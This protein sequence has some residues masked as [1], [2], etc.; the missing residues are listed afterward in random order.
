MEA[1]YYSVLFILAGLL[2]RLSLIDIQ[3][4]RLPNPLVLAV[5]ILGLLLVFAT[6][7]HTK[8]FA[9]LL[10]AILGILFSA[11]PALLVSLIFWA[12][13]G[14]EGFGAGDIKLL[15]ALGLF[16]GPAGIA[17]LPAACLFACFY[18]SLIFIT[19]FG[20]N[21]IKV[22]T[23]KIPKKARKQTIAFGPYIS[24]ATLI[25][26]LMPLLAALL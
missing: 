10:S 22:I 25:I 20:R 23:G 3:S 7:L 11:G 21:P 1:I 13:R 5:A 16:V 4:R 18:M 17:I 9:P 8:S 24:V 15:A 14:E 2:L 19:K 26:L 12:L 6:C